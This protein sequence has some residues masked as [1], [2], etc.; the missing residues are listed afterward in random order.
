MG[1]LFLLDWVGY[2]GR[3]NFTWSQ[4]PSVYCYSSCVALP[5]SILNY[6]QY[7]VTTNY[8]LDAKTLSY[9]FGWNQQ[10]HIPSIDKQTSQ[11]N[12]QTK[13]TCLPTQSKSLEL[14][15]SNTLF[16]PSLTLARTPSCRHLRVLVLVP[17][18]RQNK[19]PPAQ[20]GHLPCYPC[21]R[22]FLNTIGHQANRG[23]SKE[24][25]INYSP[26]QPPT[27]LLATEPWLPVRG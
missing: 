1:A 12:H 10:L 7:I 23:P 9:C 2:K 18:R 5:S 22:C 16:E 3:D 13:K 15:Q 17:Q 19:A 25:A 27:P 26:T 11:Q 21:W 24:E 8:A 14:I 20:R 6:L 4:E